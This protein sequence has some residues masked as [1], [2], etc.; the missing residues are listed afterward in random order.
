MLV[1]LGSIWGP[2]KQ[3]SKFLLYRELKE[4]PGPFLLGFFPG[5]MLYIHPQLPINPGE[6]QTARRACKSGGLSSVRVFL[7]WQIPFVL[8]TPHL[9][10]YPNSPIVALS[11]LHTPSHNVPLFI[12]LVKIEARFHRKTENKQTNKVKPSYGLLMFQK[13]MSLVDTKKNFLALYFRTSL[14]SFGSSF[15]TGSSY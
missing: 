1:L 2:E 9:P 6:A 14:N 12:N 10:P 8:P 13:S 15:H 5:L 11:S 4:R 3:F 7:S